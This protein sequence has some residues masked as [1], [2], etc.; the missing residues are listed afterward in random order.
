MTYRGPFQLQLAD[1]SEL[2]GIRCYLCTLH[3]C[4]NRLSTIY[5]ICVPS[6]SRNKLFRVRIHS[7]HQVPG[8]PQEGTYQR[9][10]TSSWTVTVQPE[11]SVRRKMQ[12][13]KAILL[14]FAYNVWVIAK[15]LEAIAAFVQ[16][17]PSFSP[18]CRAQLIEGEKPA[19]LSSAFRREAKQQAGCCQLMNVMVMYRT[20]LVCVA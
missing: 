12:V 11:A 5:F 3:K 19:I 9:S 15:L 20:W 1:D 8:S 7:V 10:D 18:A 17:L 6:F 14:L 13:G 4:F 16:F 2:Q